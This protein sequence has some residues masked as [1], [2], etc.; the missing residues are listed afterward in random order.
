MEAATSLLQQA[1]EMPP[2]PYPG[3]RPFEA[4]EWTIF[5]GREAMTRQ[6][7]RLVYKHRFVMV[8]GA[9]GSGKS[10]LIRAGVLPRIALEQRLSGNAWI[11]ET[12]KPSEG[13]LRRLEEI[14]EAHFPAAQFLEGRSQ[15]PDSPH[16]TW[17]EEILK[18][19]GLL[20]VIQAAATK[21][22]CHLCLL[23]DQF[24]E[25]FR[26][27]GWS[28]PSEAKAFVDILNRAAQHNNRAP[29]LSVILT[30]RSDYLGA[31][32]RYDGFA[33]TV[34]RC[35]YLLP[36]MG[37]FELLL[38]IH[39]PARLY[40]GEVTD[41]A[42]AAVLA[43]TMAEAD[44]LPILQHALMRAWSG[45]PNRQTGWKLDVA[46]FER[47]GGVANA[48][49]AHADEVLAEAIGKGSARKT[50]EE[51]LEWVFRA[52]TDLDA[53]G[54]G[55]RRTRRFKELADVAGSDV[56]ART[57]RALI[58]RFRNP[59]CSFLAPYGK[60]RLKDDTAVEISHEAL[61][62]K[63]GRLSDRQWEGDRPR[64]WVRR[65]FQ[66][67][68]R[69]RALVFLGQNEKNLLSPGATVQWLP[70]FNS[71][72]KRPAWA[73]RYAMVRPSPAS[74]AAEQDDRE[75]QD[76]QRLFERSERN[77]TSFTTR[78]RRL[79]TG[80]I[81]VA[82]LAL[83]VAGGFLIEKQAKLEIAKAEA[84]AQ[85]TKAAQAQ[86]QALANVETGIVTTCQKGHAQEGAGA[87]NQC[88]SNLIGVLSAPPAPYAAAPPAGRGGSVSLRPTV[89]AV[90]K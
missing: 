67:G 50:R 57:V 86:L 28:A 29:R 36:K 80:V 83:V 13:A 10:S 34:N 15:L 35:Q 39:E 88:I 3:L 78:S 45:L 69:W 53:D 48:L 17:A 64:G 52:L 43:A 66:E 11:C 21:K 58:D 85:T 89:A 37:D 73:R 33:E 41:E 27:T 42:A 81:G 62:R 9:S 16:R 24:E 20:G 65:E 70:W 79:L 40:G 18:G 60:D 59:D 56:D 25:L 72:L 8:H 63:W 1:R 87:V 55:V 31:C 32:A 23:V 2:A 68:Q 76:V 84:A 54:L 51:A 46:D 77:L 82:F 61:I 71:I 38:A 7:I 47:V 90:S 49:P 19:S 22:D 74:T 44:R 6:V 26:L 12:L 14:L 75:L 5:F 4:G 30:M